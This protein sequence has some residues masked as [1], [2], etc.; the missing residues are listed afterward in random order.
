MTQY[1]MSADGVRIAWESVGDGAPVVLVHG[2]ASSREQNWRSAGW[3]DRLA[4]EG[5]RV[6]SFD[7]RGHGLSDKPHETEAYGAHMV[8]DI[9]AVMDAAGVPQADLV[10][11]SMGSMMTIGMLLAHPERARRAVLAGLG[12]TYFKPSDPNKHPIAD[13]LLVDDF[14]SITDPIARRFRV[15]ASQKGKDRVALAACMRSRGRKYTP[16]EL[17]RVVNPV[18]VI[19]GEND[20]ITGPPGPL[21]EAFPNGRAVVLP[22]KDHMSAVGDPAAKRAVLEFLRE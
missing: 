21:A 4:R 22:G 15:F 2:F 7:N 5:F 19:C 6:V 1:V 10:G 11:Y 3:V 20:D 9:V 13:A 16:E 12:A 17:R 14:E 8:E 18:L